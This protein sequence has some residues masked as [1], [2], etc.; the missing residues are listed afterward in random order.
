MLVRPKDPEGNRKWVQEDYLLISP[1]A[2]RWYGHVVEDAVTHQ[3]RPARPEEIESGAAMCD[4]ITN[5]RH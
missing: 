3:L 1:G 4:D 2:D 5:F